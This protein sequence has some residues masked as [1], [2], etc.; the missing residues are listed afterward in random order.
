MKIAVTGHTGFIGRNLVKRLE[1]L[2]HEVIK[3]GRDYESVYCH[4]VYHLACPSTTKY[5]NENPLEV[6]NIIIDGTRRALEICPTATFIN[7]STKGVL[8]IEGD[9][10]QISYNLAKRCMETYVK[11]SGVNYKNYRIPSV[12]GIDMHD[13][14]FIKR[15]VDGRAYCPNEPHKIHHIAHIDD[16]VESM[17]DL[18]DIE[19]EDITLGEIYEL[20]SSGRRR[21]YRTTPDQTTIE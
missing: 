17:I 2:G 1:S 6:M 20:F 13:D 19:V 15:C 7:A 16:V 4:R 21:I 5:I 12:Y 3:I 14:M 11:N 10:P 9:T 18:R 8:E